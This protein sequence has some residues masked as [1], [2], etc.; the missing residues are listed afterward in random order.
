M[1]ESKGGRRL[2]VVLTVAW[3]PSA[4]TEQRG[5]SGEL[6]GRSGAISSK[7]SIV[8]NRKGAQRLERG[9]WGGHREDGTELG[10]LCRDGAMPS[11]GVRST[12][13]FLETSS[14]G[15]EYLKIFIVCHGGWEIRTL[16]DL[17]YS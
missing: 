11:A 16:L 2:T 3:N 13:L 6:S 4:T 1:S 9:C 7:P 12:T 14:F 10:F 8:L 15:G 5:S 17:V